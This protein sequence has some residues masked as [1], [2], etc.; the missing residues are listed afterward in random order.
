[1][2]WGGGGGVSDYLDTEINMLFLLSF[3]AAEKPAKP[4]YVKYMGLFAFEARNPD[5]LTF[6]PGDIIWVRRFNINLF[7]NEHSMAGRNSFFHIQL[8]P[9]HLCWVG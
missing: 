4:G 3:I 1:M 5:E 7:F 2:S 6:N 9:K 8:I